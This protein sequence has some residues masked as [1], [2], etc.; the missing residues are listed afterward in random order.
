MAG[1]Q[2]FKQNKNGVNYR[3]IG[4]VSRAMHLIYPQLILYA[5]K[6]VLT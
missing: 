6:L 3:V 2:Y 4:I 5:D 1:F